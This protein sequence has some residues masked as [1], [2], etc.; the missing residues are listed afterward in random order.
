MSS[1]PIFAHLQR[2]TFDDANPTPYLKGVKKGLDEALV[3]RMSIEKKEPKWM[4]EHRI[5]SLKIFKEKP[6]PTWGGAFQSSTLKTSSTTPHPER[7]R[8]II[9]KKCRRKSGRSTIASGFRKRSG[10]CLR[11]SVRSTRAKWS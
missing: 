8:P 9:G 10:K 3:R 4:L 1:T 6:L 2:S 5:E 7:W 11:E